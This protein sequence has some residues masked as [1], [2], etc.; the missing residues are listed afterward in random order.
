MNIYY[1]TVIPKYALD[2]RI[3]E[4]SKVACISKLIFCVRNNYFEYANHLDFTF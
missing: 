4:N 1:K 2:A 3:G